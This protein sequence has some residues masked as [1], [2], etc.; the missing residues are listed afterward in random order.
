MGVKIDAVGLG[1][2]AASLSQRLL[3]NLSPLGPASPPAGA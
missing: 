3:I 1:S 2:S